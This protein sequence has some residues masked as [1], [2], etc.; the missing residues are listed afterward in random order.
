MT[1]MNFTRMHTPTGSFIT[2]LDYGLIYLQ[3][4]FL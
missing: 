3:N 4:L 2:K 1:F